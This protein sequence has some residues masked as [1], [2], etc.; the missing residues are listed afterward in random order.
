L[1]KHFGGIQALKGVDLDIFAGEVHGLVGAN[2]A[3]KSTLIKVLAGIATS[4]Q[5][6]PEL[7]SPGVEPGAILERIGEHHPGS[8]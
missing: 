1:Q 2:G 5:P 8:T 4:C 7:Y 3:G 6:G